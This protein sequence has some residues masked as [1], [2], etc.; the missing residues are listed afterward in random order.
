MVNPCCEEEN[1]NKEI[2]NIFRLKKLNH[3]AIIDIRNI[4]R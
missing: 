2:R 3:T 1:I 4:F